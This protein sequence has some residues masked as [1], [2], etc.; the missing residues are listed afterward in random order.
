MDDLG[1]D[2]AL[3]GWF[4]GCDYLQTFMRDCCVGLI[5]RLAQVRE[6]RTCVCTFNL[7][8]LR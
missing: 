7:K 5:L 8:L 1:V 4:V 3:F 2:V 6:H